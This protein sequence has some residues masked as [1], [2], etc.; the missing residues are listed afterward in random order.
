[1]SQRSFFTFDCLLVKFVFMAS[2]M[3]VPWQFVQAAEIELSTA[4]ITELNAAMDE[5]A[6]NSEQLV[7]MYL[8]RIE[9]YNKN[10]PAINAVFMLNPNAIAEAQALDRE[11]LAQGR[12]SPM[13]G[14]PVVIKDNL[15]TAD[16]PTSAGSFLLK[17]SFPP[18]DAFLVKQLKDAGAIIL[19]KLNLSEFASGGSTNSVGGEI[20]N[21]HSLTRSPAGSS[22]GT[23]AAIAAVF[24]AVGLGTDTG[25]S[26]R[27]PSSANGIAGLKTTHGLLSRD[28]VVPLALTFDTV[29]P[30]AR[31]ISDLAVV[32]GV[33]TGID[34]ADPS[35]QKSEGIFEKDYTQFLDADALQ[36]ARIGV[37]RVFMK[38]D[39]EVDW[40]VESALQ[41]MRDAGAEVIDVELPA[42]LLESRGEFYRAIRYPEFRAQIADY[43][44]TLA[45]EYP[46]TL[47]DLIAGAMKLTASRE[48]GAIPNP[49][50][51]ALML[52]ED[53]SAELDN[54]Q[55]T[56]VLEHA[57]PL[58]RATLQGLMDAENLDAIV[59]PTMPTPA[60]LTE[61]PPSGTLSAGSGGSPVILANLSGF[62]D[63]IVPAGFTSRGLPVTLSFM[64]RAFS[65]PRLLG[66]GYAL[67]QRLHAIRLPILTPALPGE[68][69][70]VN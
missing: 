43:L 16:M 32:L 12:R 20:G 69:M 36:G 25:G 35:T 5:G 64:G 48:D 15:D 57:L 2:I 37:A 49:S 40:V 52:E 7:Q 4:T 26:V 54:Y 6:L 45:P 70:I 13:H 19:A 21:P 61:S 22:G 56:A 31:S 14:I 3:V 8:A 23:G 46:K 18:D 41:S 59:Y 33:M 10:G 17:N 29:G 65:E 66:L 63:L 67:E 28:G 42:W 30:M 1:M 34:P 68:T 39:A 44:A 55:Y 62:P 58:V 50:R 24:A 27:M 51:W 53:K 38:S 11:R 60:G 47:A 9:A